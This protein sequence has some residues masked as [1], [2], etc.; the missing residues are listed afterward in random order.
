MKTHQRYHSTISFTILSVIV[1][2]LSLV[3]MLSTDEHMN[4]M[5]EVFVMTLGITLTLIPILYWCEKK[6]KHY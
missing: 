3:C 6:A 2:L 4:L 1:Y 5:A